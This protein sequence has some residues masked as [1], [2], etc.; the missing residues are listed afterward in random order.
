MFDFLKKKL[1]LMHG[2]T[3]IVKLE[4]LSKELGHSLYVK[5]DDLTGMAL[6]GNKIRKLEYHFYQAKQQD[7]NCVV[8]C[9]GIQSNHARAT[10]VLAR[11]FGWRPVLILG[12]SEP[13]DACQGN[14]LL[15]KLLDAEIRWTDDNSLFRYSDDLLEEAA[16]DLR[17]KGYRPYV[18]PMGGTDTTGLSGYISAGLEIR[19]QEKK[20]HVAFDAVFCAVGTGGT[21][22][23]LI[24]CK[25]LIDWRIRIYGVNVMLDADYFHDRID[26]LIRAYKDEHTLTAAH[27]A[28]DIQMIDG[29]V[30]TGYAKS[31]PEVA[32]LIKRVAVAEGVFLDPVYTA[33]AFQGM[34]RQ[35]DDGMFSPESNILFL[36]TGGMFG[37][38][39][40][41]DGLFL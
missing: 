28:K 26:L 6:S 18:I 32:E 4:R 24:L 30:G 39:A 35:I 17:A 38:F 29:F 2:Q 7:A 1:N 23:G 37:L 33:K 19:E 10:A 16:E 21:L 40:Q 11:Q 8:T 22:G 20:M 25:E 13:K 15:D 34:L 14:L 3:P 31:T 9:G 41:A 36:H 12:G 27:H 5:R